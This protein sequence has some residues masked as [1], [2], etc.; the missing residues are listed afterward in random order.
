MRPKLVSVIDSPQNPTPYEPPTIT[1]IGSV[2]E[3]TQ[4][5]DKRM[6]TSDGFT[7]MGNNIVCVS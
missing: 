7:F 5:C 3:L 2:H 1:V 4:G 6:G